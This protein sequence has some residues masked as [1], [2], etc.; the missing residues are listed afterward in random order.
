[1]EDINDDIQ[2]FFEGYEKR[3][4][5]GLA[6]QAVAE[7]TA[8][9]FADFFVEASPVGISGGKNDA[10]FL[11]AVPKGYEF[12]RSIG[13]T[14]MEIRQIDITELN[15]MHYLV[16]VRWESFYEKDGS[17]DSM[18]F[19][20]IYFL[21]NRKSELKIFAYITGDEQAVLKERGLV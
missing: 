5:E 7:D 21:Q 15:E 18:E 20:V 1:M 3:F 12:Y 4:E 17:E 14:K 10:Q 9:V 8:R 13:I 2:A 16:D 11:E 6:G 19:S